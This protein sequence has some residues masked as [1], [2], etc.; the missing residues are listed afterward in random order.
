MER[1]CEGVEGQCGEGEEGIQVGPWPCV[2]RVLQRLCG[3]GRVQ[4]M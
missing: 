2:E 4:A 3:E 1:G